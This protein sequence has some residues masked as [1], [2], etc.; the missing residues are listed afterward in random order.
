ML[1]GIGGHFMLIGRDRELKI[2]QEAYECGGCQTVFVAGKTGVGK[3]ALLSEFIKS[4][5]GIYFTAESVNDALNLSLF[6]QTVAERYPDVPDFIDWKVA[7]HIVSQFSQGK[8]LILVIDDV[9]NLL[10]ASSNFLNSLLDVMSGATD[11]SDFLLILAGTY[12]RSVLEKL[13]IKLGGRAV[14]LDQL[15][16]FDASKMLDGFS[17]EDKLR[18]YACLGGVPKYLTMVDAGISFEENIYNLFFAQKGVLNIEPFARA[19][20]DTREPQVYNAILRAIA[21]G[22]NRLS[23][24]VEYSGE[25]KYKIAKYLKVLVDA[26]VINRIVPHGKDAENSRNGIYQI[27]DKSYLF[28]YRFVFG[29]KIHRKEFGPATLPCVFG[30]SL[31]CYVYDVISRDVCVQ[32]LSRSNSNGRL[33]FE[34]ESVGMWWDDGTKIDVLASSSDSTQTLNLESKWLG[35]VTIDEVKP[36]VEKKSSDEGHWLFYLSR[37][38]FTDDAVN[39]ARMFKNVKLLSVSDLF[40]LT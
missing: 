4:K 14:Y 40:E 16:Y 9:S 7:L 3:S 12:S 26:D 22:A 35:Q 30:N 11:S 15:D 6:H 5:P 31:E 23:S 18:L 13:N 33:P 19:R 34:A 28:W 8:R 27:T 24:I 36:V 20:T 2:L 25:E 1:N 10:I 39:H 37:D 21:C 29:N 32:Y 38:G 17:S